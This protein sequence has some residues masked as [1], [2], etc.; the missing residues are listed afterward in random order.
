MDQHER[1][2]EPG[3]A[4]PE[5]VIGLAAERLRRESAE[6]QARA[7]TRAQDLVVP[8]ARAANE[9]LCVV[10]LRGTVIALSG[11]IDQGNAGSVTA[12]ILPML[13]DGDNH[14]DMAGVY[15]VDSVGVSVIL[16]IHAL[17]VER[18]AQLKLTC[19][20]PVYGVLMMSGL[21]DALPALRIVEAG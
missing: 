10:L 3:A 4:Q 2:S 21:V 8:Q 7:R 12:R 20:P 11:E 18:G 1:V 16:K 17:L 9:T 5:T 15:F 6:T 13:H 19:S 14:L